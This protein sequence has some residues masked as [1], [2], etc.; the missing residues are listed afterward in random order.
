MPTPFAVALGEYQGRVGEMEEVVDQLIWHN[1]LFI[2]NRRNQTFL[3]RR[4]LQCLFNLQ[5]LQASLSG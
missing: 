1:T 4:S 5:T 2:F 3:N